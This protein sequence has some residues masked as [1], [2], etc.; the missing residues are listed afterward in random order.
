[1]C[2]CVCMSIEAE[3]KKERA[4]FRDHLFRF[5]FVLCVAS[6]ASSSVVSA[7]VLPKRRP[8]KSSS[9]V[10]VTF[11]SHSGTKLPH[12]NSGFLYYYKFELEGL[13]ALAPRVREQQPWLY[14]YVFH[15]VAYIIMVDM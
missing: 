4:N 6:S 2:V 5:E 11:P 9:C 15:V 14:T 1:M 12:E 8:N 3:R 10:I 7:A 13:I